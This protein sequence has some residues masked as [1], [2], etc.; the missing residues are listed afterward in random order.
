MEFHELA[1]HSVEHSIARLL[2]VVLFVLE[3][4][5]A[6]MNPRTEV[7]EL[8]KVMRRTINALERVDNASKMDWQ[9]FQTVIQ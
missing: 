5:A 7:R 3:P 1:T 6:G 2:R 4:Y 8:A 9:I